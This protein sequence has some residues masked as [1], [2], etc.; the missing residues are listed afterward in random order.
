MHKTGQQRLD[1][2]QIHTP[3]KPNQTP[4][5]RK[6][7]KK[8]G[9][10]NSPE[11]LKLHGRVTPGIRVMNSSASL[12]ESDAESPTA[13]SSARCCT[14]GFP[15]EH[16]QE[17]AG[18]CLLPRCQHR[19]WALPPKRATWQGS[20]AMLR[21]GCGTGKDGGHTKPLFCTADPPTPHS[22]RGSNLISPITQW[23]TAARIRI[24]EQKVQLESCFL[25]PSSKA[26]SALG[27]INVLKSQRSLGLAFLPLSLLFD[28]SFLVFP[29]T[30]SAN[31]VLPGRW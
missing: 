1:A 11:K 28:N 18:L 22:R 16:S 20:C 17:R 31:L 13:G 23:Q 14:R 21:E 24:T 6:N 8:E 5:P 12:T 2:F 4:S 9:K 27:G 3:K 10:K 30:S 29:D 7:K 26:P 15:W 19:V 25:P